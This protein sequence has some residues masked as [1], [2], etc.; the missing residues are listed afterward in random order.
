MSNNNQ[1]IEWKNI[2]IISLDKLEH[3]ADILIN[4]ENIRDKNKE[5]I[6]VLNEINTERE[7]VSNKAFRTKDTT[8]Q[9]CLIWKVEGLNIAY[10]MIV[11]KL[12]FDEHI[13][14]L[15]F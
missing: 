4:K 10:R 12:N 7:K 6:K 11:D 1:K 14:A 9:L 2:S 13:E 15:K 8:E 3:P 5:L